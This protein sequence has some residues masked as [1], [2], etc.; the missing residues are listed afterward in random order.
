MDYE[1]YIKKHFTYDPRSGKIGRDDRKNSNGS[2]DKGGYLILKVKG[3]QF[4]AHRVAWF[5]YYGSFPE[6]VIDHINGIKSDNRI[7]NLRDVEQKRNVKNTNRSPNKDTGV[8]GIH[9][10]STT[11]GLK[12]NYT[13][14]IN[15][16]TYRF[17][18]L[19]EAI[20]FRR[21]KGL[22]TTEQEF[23]NDRLKQKAC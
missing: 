20:R 4:K 15:G 10:D 16:K 17:Y 9:Y 13:T 1:N 19:E 14:R 11:K 3:K 8:V 7:S 21:E 23:L 2:Y 5:L 12:K 18:E 22:P 6:N